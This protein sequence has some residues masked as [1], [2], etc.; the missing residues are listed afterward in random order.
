MIALLIILGVITILISVILVI[1]II[2]TEKCAKSFAFFFIILS[3]ALLLLIG[4]AVC[5]EYNDRIEKET[6]CE[7]LQDIDI[8]NIELSGDKV[9]VYA[10]S[11]EDKLEVYDFDLKETNGIRK[12]S[13]WAEVIVVQDGQEPTITPQL[14]KGFTYRVK[15]TI[16]T[17]YPPVMKEVKVE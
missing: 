8:V 17:T 4:K 16:K 9:T 5:D 11:E 13:R 2:R 10:V 6:L 1:M 15:V 14:I 12:T 7:K 3:I